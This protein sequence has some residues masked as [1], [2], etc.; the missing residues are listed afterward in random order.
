MTNLVVAMTV[1]TKFVV[2]AVTMKLVITV[3][4][5]KLALTA[6]TKKL[7]VTAVMTKLVSTVVTTIKLARNSYYYGAGHIGILLRILP[8][9]LLS[10]IPWFIFTVI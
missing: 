1:T 9:P 8:P 7:V 5:T 4:M 3:V 2:K 6:V 10:V